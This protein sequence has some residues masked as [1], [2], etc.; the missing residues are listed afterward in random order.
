M[1]RMKLWIFK[2]KGNTNLMVNLLGQKKIGVFHSQLLCASFIWFH[3]LQRAECWIPPNV[4]H[5]KC[6]SSSRREGIFR[7]SEAYHMIVAVLHIITWICLTLR[8]EKDLKN[9]TGTCTGT[10]HTWNPVFLATYKV[11][12]N[13]IGKKWGKIFQK[14]TPSNLSWE[15]HLHFGESPWNHHRFTCLICPTLQIPEKHL[16][17]CVL[18]T[19]ENGW[20]L[21]V[22]RDGWSFIIYNPLYHCCRLIS[23]RTWTDGATFKFLKE[24]KPAE[25]KKHEKKQTVAFVLRVFSKRRG[26]PQ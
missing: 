6:I 21:E 8:E 23:L 7:W 13:F 2:K 16:A 26:N 4:T 19:P 22:G 15:T 9:S 24:H 3:L 11:A 5:H 1:S 10:T 17:F 25:W 18:Q 14:H 20:G 12:R